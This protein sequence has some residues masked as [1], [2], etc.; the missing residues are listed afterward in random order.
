MLTAYSIPKVYTDLGVDLSNLSCIMLDVDPLDSSFIQEE[1]L[2]YDESWSRGGGGRELTPHVTLRHG[3]LPQ[4]KREHVDAVLDKVIIP[5]TISVR[6]TV[7]RFA[8][9]GSAPYEVIIA[10]VESMSLYEIHG[11]LGMLPNIS[12]FPT[13]QP[14]VTLAYVRAGWLAENGPVTI[15]NTNLDVRGINYGRQLS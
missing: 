11:A 10:E 3:L 15:E 13:Y 14:H 8:S 4:V 1:D 12:T 9:P 5:T 2:Y 6:P 7:A